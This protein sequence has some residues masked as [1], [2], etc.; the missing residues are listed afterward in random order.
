MLK[1]LLNVDNAL[2]PLLL[3]PL[4]PVPHSAVAPPPLPPPPP[5]PAPAEAAY[6]FYT[7]S[8]LRRQYDPPATPASA[9]QSPTDPYADVTRLRVRPARHPCLYPGAR[10]AG[11]QRSGSTSYE[12]AVTLVVRPPPSPPRPAP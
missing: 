4:L 1:I 3:P 9:L 5:A 8:H 2:A 12:V 6:P 10:F 11:T 7:P